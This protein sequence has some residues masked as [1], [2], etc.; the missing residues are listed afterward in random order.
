MVKIQKLGRFRVGRVEKKF[1]KETKKSAKLEF[2]M[3]KIEKLGK[4]KVGIFFQN[5]VHKVGV[6]EM[7]VNKS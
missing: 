6:D 4:F 7:T 5:K 2:G 3:V 1:P